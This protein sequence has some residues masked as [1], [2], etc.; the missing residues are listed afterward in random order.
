MD[1]QQ[2]Q[3][4]SPNGNIWQ[5]YSTRN[6]LLV[7]PKLTCMLN[8]YMLVIP[9]NNYSGCPT[10]T[11]TRDVTEEVWTAMFLGEYWVVGRWLLW[12]GTRGCC[13]ASCWGTGLLRLGCLKP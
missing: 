7:R 2:F 1:L 13:W 12:L 5:Q 8:F 10:F 3:Q 6:D 4:S 9:F 11:P